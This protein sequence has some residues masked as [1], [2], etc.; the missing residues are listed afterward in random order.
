[1]DDP[2]DNTLTDLERYKGDPKLFQLSRRIRKVS[3]RMA[4]LERNWRNF[5]KS[6][7]P[8]FARESVVTNLRKEL[9]AERKKR[10]VV[11][12]WLWGALGAIALKVLE[13]AIE[14]LMK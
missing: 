6:E 8:R 2:N 11:R 4:Q 12:N 13:T 3:K 10:I 5:V 7:V 9:E 14:R 1:M